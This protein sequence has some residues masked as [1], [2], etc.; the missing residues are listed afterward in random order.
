V[1]KLACDGS[2]VAFAVGDAVTPLHE[3]DVATGYVHAHRRVG[4]VRAATNS[5]GTV[6][7][8]ASYDPYGQVRTQSGRH[9]AFGFAGSYTDGTGLLYLRARYMDPM[10]GQF[11]TVDPLVG[12]TGAPYLYADGDPINRTDPLGLSSFWSGAAAGVKQFA[13]STLTGLGGLMVDPAGTLGDVAGNLEDV[14]VANG[15][16]LMGSVAVFNQFNPVY[17][18]AQMFGGIADA[19]SAAGAGCAATF[20]FLQVASFFAPGGGGG[21][22]RAAEA[23]VGF[24]GPDIGLA[25]RLGEASGARFAVSSAGV[26]T[27][28]LAGSVP[29]AI[30]LGNSGIYEMVA[31]RTGAQAFMIADEGWQ[32]MSPAERDVR[33]LRFLDKAI[34]QG[35]E[36][37][38][39]SR[40]TEQNTR[41]A[42]G[43][44][45]RYL[46]SKG[47]RLSD[48]MKYMIPPG[49]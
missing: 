37:W 22:A 9:G 11:L 45:L 1:R 19:T 6:V 40:P 5:A 10:T 24:V 39:A 48:D 47:Y 25:V 20:G 17:L 28:R 26:A 14:Y 49:A 18:A 30:V 2:V 4:S 7:G 33:N 8:T 23:G 46:K 38:L 21:V 34:A 41:G 13:V 27:D 43:M 16:G 12:S 3:V 29:N 31:A 32:A 15:E 35:K 36:I 44:E 42:F